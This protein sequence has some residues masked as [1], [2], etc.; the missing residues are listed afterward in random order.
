[1][2]EQE[3]ELEKRQS[4]AVPLLLFMA[5]LLGLI[6]L[7]AYFFME[8]R[9][10]LTPR[11][12]SGVVSNILRARGTTTVTFHTGLITERYEE[13]PE[14]VRYRFLEKAGVIKIGK[15]KGEKAP[16][17]L[18]AKGEELIKQIPNVQQSRDE[19]G[20]VSYVIPLAARKLVEV[21]KITMSGPQRATVEYTWQ[22]DPNL[23]GEAFDASGPLLATFDT[24]DRMS[25]IDKYG[26]R[27]YHA[28][29]TREVVM[30][31]NGPQG[32]QLVSE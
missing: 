7:A 28:A 9:Q 23:L 27:F 20:I 26:A 5:L 8:S 24:N 32:W 12:A 25:L 29:P 22:W 17:A 1:M 14:D 4:A 6:G 31:G 10:V 30:V 16:V 21:S 3:M 13:S 19:D 18:T 15:I 11:E 2:F